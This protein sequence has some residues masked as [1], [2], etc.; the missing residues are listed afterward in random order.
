[1]SRWVDCNSDRGYEEAKRE[2][3]ERINKVEILRGFG[4]F[5]WDKMPYIVF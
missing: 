5:M 3:E 1:M 2:R 4:L